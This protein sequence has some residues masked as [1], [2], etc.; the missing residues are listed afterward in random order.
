MHRTIVQNKII[1]IICSCL[2]CLANIYRPSLGKV[3]FSEEKKNHST[4]NC[5]H[6]NGTEADFKFKF[7]FF[8]IKKC[9]KSWNNTYNNFF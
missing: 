3:Q 4:Q 7:S 9:I 1:R 2:F 8:L 5:M 6:Y